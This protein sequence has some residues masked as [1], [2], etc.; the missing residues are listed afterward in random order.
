MRILF[1]YYF[2]GR[3]E[4]SPNWESKSSVERI[5]SPFFVQGLHKHMFGSLDGVCATL[6]K[7]E[8]DTAFAL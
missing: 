7:E 1:F 5:V 2:H 8:E 4:L 6:A 3:D